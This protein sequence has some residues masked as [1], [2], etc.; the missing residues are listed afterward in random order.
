[1]LKEHLVCLKSGEE[2]PTDALLLGTGFVPSLNFFD[3]SLLKQLDLP[4]TPGDEPT[5]SA[6]KWALLEKAADQQVIEKYPLL[7]NPP[8]DIFRK[9]TPT[10]PYRLYK[11]MAPISDASDRSIAI[12]GH[13]LVPNYFR[14]GEIQAIWATAY[15]DGQLK[16]PPVEEMEK[17]VALFTAWCRRRYLSNGEKGN[18]VLFEVAFY[19]DRL[20]EQVGLKSHR[21]G[22]FWDYFGPGTMVD[23][24]GLGKEYLERYG[25][26]V[27]TPDD[28]Q[29]MDNQETT[30]LI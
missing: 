6:H 16:L 17:E 9:P 3:H 25:R 8:A 14:V 21:R 11:G 10:T 28:W 2:L 13:L 23:L 30:P 29:P 5:A 7:A 20:L 24:R 1:M 26:D 27:V 19:N 15:L 18:H 4:Y 12:L 22:W